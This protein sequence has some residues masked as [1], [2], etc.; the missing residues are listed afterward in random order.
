MLALHMLIWGAYCKEATRKNEH[1]I[2]PTFFFGVN[3]RVTMCIVAIFCGKPSAASVFMFMPRTGRPLCHSCV[4]TYLQ[5]N[6]SVF[7][8]G[9]R[10]CYFGGAA[11]FIRPQCRHAMSNTAIC[12]CRRTSRH[13]IH[14]PASVSFQPPQ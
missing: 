7:I 4:T 2:R 1:A 5:S 12:I 3:V 10:P 13:I 9:V 6:M 11:P 8:V 14:P